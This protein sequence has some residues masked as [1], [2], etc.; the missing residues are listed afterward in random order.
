M[1]EAERGINSIDIHWVMYSVFRRIHKNHSDFLNTTTWLA[2]T[3]ARTVSNKTINPS[4]INVSRLELL[5]KSIQSEMEKIF[6]ECQ[7]N[8]G[9]SKRSFI[10]GDDDGEIPYPYH[11][12]ISYFEYVSDNTLL[13]NKTGELKRLYSNKNGLKMTK[14]SIDQALISTSESGTNGIYHYVLLLYIN[15]YKYV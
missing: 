7:G 3:F 14:E 10:A 1:T 9:I 4:S 6:D 5:D 12:E 11:G 2:K 15:M 8:C 13:K